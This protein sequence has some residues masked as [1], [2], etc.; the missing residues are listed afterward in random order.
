MCHFEHNT[1][2]L[3]FKSGRGHILLKQLITVKEETAKGSL[4]LKSLELFNLRFLQLFDRE[5][6]RSDRRR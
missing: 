4:E 1:Q 2:G 5:F 6:L 3:R